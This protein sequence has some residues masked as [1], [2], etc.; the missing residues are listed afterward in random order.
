LRLAKK[1]ENIS[2]SSHELKIKI[3]LKSSHL[4]ADKKLKQKVKEEDSH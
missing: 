4:Y 3:G 2:L 1:L